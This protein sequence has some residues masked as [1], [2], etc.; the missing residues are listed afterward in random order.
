MS[1]MSHATATAI[2]P[3]A[4]STHKHTTLAGKPSEHLTVA[5]VHINPFPAL[6]AL[7]EGSG[8]AS[9]PCPP[10][11]VIPSP[12]RG[13]D[14]IPPP[15]ACVRPEDDHHDINHGHDNGQNV[16]RNA[17]VYGDK[18]RHNNRFCEDAAAASS[19]SYIDFVDK[20]DHKGRHRF[21]QEVDEEGGEEEEEEGSIAHYEVVKEAKLAKI[22]ATSYHDTTTN[23]PSRNKSDHF[24]GGLERM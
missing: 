19:S 24:S 8:S 14:E 13:G 17:V 22:L 23:P 6:G 20:R 18:A 16:D 5:T 11:D 9:H 3:H 15:G 4:T 21:K 7:R 2:S 1:P 12:R 10:D